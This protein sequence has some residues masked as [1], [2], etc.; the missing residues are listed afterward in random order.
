MMMMML[1]L[2][3]KPMVVVTLSKLSVLCFYAIRNLTPFPFFTHA[4]K[5]APGFE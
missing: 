1:L 3:A 5:M 2:M 4:P